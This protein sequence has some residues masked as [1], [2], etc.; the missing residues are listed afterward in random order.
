MTGRGI[1]LAA[2]ACQALLGQP[3]RDDATRWGGLAS[4]LDLAAEAGYGGV[5]LSTGVFPMDAPDGWWRD[6]A[7]LVADRG[8]EIASLNSL[9][10]SL[11]DPDYAALGAQRIE[12]ALEVAALVGSDTLN[13]ALGV[14]WERLDA[15]RFLGVADPPGGS[16]SAS[17]ADFEVTPA[18]LDRFADAAA[19]RGVELVLE[20]HYCSIADSA[21]A[22]GRLLLQMQNPIAVN[23]DLVNAVWAYDEA[24][25]GW[26]PTLRRLAPASSGVWHVKNCA[27]APGDGVV[28]R[29]ATL[30]DGVIDYDVACDILGDAG[31]DGWV[32]V[33]TCGA[34]DYR[35][36]AVS[37]AEFFTTRA[38]K[39]IAS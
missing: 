23:P 38:Q 30:A 35:S 29:D 11:C 32:S 21:A 34:P 12:R 6:I 16:R 26:E 10:S 15:N 36:F 31:F 24:D 18:T 5:D 39:G 14:P 4:F 3:D 27:A 20:L 25:E 2:H 33:E 9:R 28:L 1:A 7:R 19:E 37:G 17:A 22:I 8:L 13:V